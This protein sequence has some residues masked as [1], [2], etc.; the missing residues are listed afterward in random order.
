LPPDLTAHVRALRA[1]TGKPICVG[2][3][4]ST[5]AQVA[6]V[7][8]VAD[9]AIVGSAIVRRMNEC[10]DRGDSPAALADSVAGFIHDLSS[11]LP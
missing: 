4:V 9:G 6:T 5:P 10:V 1:D 7:C 8:Q 2:F 11:L 3:G